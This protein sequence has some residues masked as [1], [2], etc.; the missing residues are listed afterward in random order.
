MALR[1]GTAHRGSI[2]I[3]DA[4]A[5][6]TRRTSSRLRGRSRTKQAAF[7][8]PQ[9]I[10]RGS[11]LEPCVSEQVRDSDAQDRGKP[12]ESCGARVR[13]AGFLFTSGCAPRLDELELVLG[14]TRLVCERL[15]RKPLLHPQPSQR[16]SQTTCTFLVPH[17]FSMRTRPGK[18]HP[19]QQVY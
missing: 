17:V 9:R 10:V 6:R 18:A 13:W 15:L 3:A 16:T 7:N 1:Y 2:E 4:D 19:I 14:D 5:G 12:T 11:A 8:E